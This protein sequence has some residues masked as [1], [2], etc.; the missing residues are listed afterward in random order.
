MISHG[1]LGFGYKCD[2]TNE[3]ENLTKLN[4]NDEQRGRALSAKVSGHSSIILFELPP[5]L[6]GDNITWWGLSPRK[7]CHHN[8]ARASSL[9][10]NYLNSFCT[11]KTWG[12]LNFF[13]KQN[14]EYEWV[15]MRSKQCTKKY[16]TICAQSDFKMHQGPWYTW[17][18]GKRIYSFF[19]Q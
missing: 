1:Y 16:I 19:P 5:L 2:I 9:P 11:T 7:C 4:L 3:F 14:I 10:R 12:Q 15:Q 6:A 17:Y 13:P 18:P 8:S